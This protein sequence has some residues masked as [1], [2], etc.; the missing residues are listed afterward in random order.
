MCVIVHKPAGEILEEKDIRT[1]FSVNP[2]GFGY[3]YYDKDKKRIV[4]RKG[5]EY[6]E[7][8][9]VKTFN[10]LKDIDACFH[11]RYK[12]DG[13]IVDAQCHP[14]KILDKKRHGMDMYL[15]HN[16]V[17]SSARKHIENKESDTQA[18]CRK[19]LKPILRKSPQLIEQEAF[20]LLIEDYIGS[21]SKLCFMYGKGRVLK[22]N[23]SAGDT[24]NNCWVSNTYS[25]REN[26]R[27]KNSTGGFT[28]NTTTTTTPKTPVTPAQNYS[29]ANRHFG[30]NKIEK[31][32]F[33]NQE[34]SIG[35][36][37]WIFHHEDETFFTEGKAVRMTETNI[38]IEFKDINDNLTTV[39]FWLDTGDSFGVSGKTYYAIPSTSFEDSRNNNAP[40]KKVGDSGVDNKESL[41]K[42]K[43]PAI[44]R[45][46]ITYKGANI[47]TTDRYNGV[48]ESSDDYYGEEGIS[49]FDVYA[50]STLERLKFFIDRPDLSFNMF[51]D[52][53][54]NFIMFEEVMGSQTYDSD[55]DIAVEEENELLEMKYA[56][57]MAS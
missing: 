30:S 28:R 46:D 14:F 11:Y 1:A 51:Q 33:L 12:T 8:D 15:M 26:H 55:D 5:L 50:K 4:A 16:G 31:V 41:K 57:I 37:M 43:Q 45:W 42:S 36:E 3:M 44:Q 25:F 29:Y 56:N 48:L 19:F 34:V 39:M 7:D 2:H 40:F 49:I 53:I 18:F 21:G 9:I 22:I 24:R 10:K 6:K 23:E 32:S 35:D 54:D 20:R 52:L 13:E 27:S 17:I 47:D 38:A